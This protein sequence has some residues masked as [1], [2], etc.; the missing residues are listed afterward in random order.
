MVF[1]EP[2]PKMNFYVLR[3]RLFELMQE[4][5][6]A[7]N[8]IN[9]YRK[10]CDL[11]DQFMIKN[12][13]TDY[14]SS[15]GQFFLENCNKYRGKIENGKRT[16][17]DMSLA[18]VNTLN[19]IVLFNELRPEKGK[20]IYPCPECYNH[21][22]QKYLSHIRNKGFRPATI[23][24]HYRYVAEFLSL[25]ARKTN[26]FS[27]LTPII[28]YPLFEHFASKGESLY[29]ISGFLKFA[30]QT[31][32]LAE[33]FS[34]LIQFPREKQKVP[35]VY[36][37]EEMCKTLQSINRQTIKGKRDYA[38]ILLAYRLGLRASDI[39]ELSFEN[40]DLIKNRINIVQIKTQLPL[41]LPLPP[42]VKNAITEY[43]A[44]RPE[45][46]CSEIFLR[47]RAPY[48]PM[49]RTS[50]NSALTKYFKKAG[51][52]SLDRKHGLHALRS[53]LASELVSENISYSV[54]QKILGHAN[55][56]S[57]NHYVRLDMEALR[58]CALPV[59]LESGQFKEILEA[60]EVKTD[61]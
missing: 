1:I 61:G 38:M 17:T 3:E 55:S 35:T 52:N 31:Q 39:T 30:F 24:G 18:F 23:D 59:P 11:L 46:S 57:I 37:K 29:C 34:L 25:V 44:V 10:I 27:D 26:R 43:L 32:L 5:H 14:D 45:S 42:E 12:S 22:L 40:V 54:T 16:M 60:A 9:T 47:S 49:R 53:T 28:L 4:N 41:S 20:K 2:P 8:S 56:S 21:I 48:V 6:Y 51:V 33:D 15:V 36:S 50:E 13:L 58:E 19:N 7:T